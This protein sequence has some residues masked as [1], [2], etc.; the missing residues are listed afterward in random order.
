MVILLTGPDSYRSLRRLEQLREAFRAKFDEAGLNTITLDPETTTATMLRDA[1]VSGG[2]FATRRMVILDPYDAK[3]SALKPA[4]LQEALADHVKGQD[5]I[6]LIREV[7]VP[8]PGRGKKTVASKAWS[9]PEATVEEFPTLT[10]MTAQRWILAEAKERGFRL[11]PAAAERLVAVVGSDTWRL[12]NELEKLGAYASGREITA[13]DIELVSVDRTESDIFR[14]LDSIGNRQTSA[15]LLLIRRE[16]QSGTHPLAVV[17]ALTRHIE[18]LLG[19]Q[20]LAPATSA[21][22]AKELSVHPY[23]A[24]KAAAQA[25]KFQRAELLRWHG[26]LVQM[27]RDLKSTNLD[28]ETLLM[29]MVGR[30]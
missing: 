16:L 29:S 24:T 19:A 22:I 27:D 23:V 1:V 6:V 5:V 3:R 30:P 14:L 17:S 20:A 18:H 21:A 28:A 2:L 13:S 4:A 25:K 10:V 9:M 26:A 15:A 11:T 12:H 7:V 8:M